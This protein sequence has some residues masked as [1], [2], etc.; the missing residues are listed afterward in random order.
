MKCEFIWINKANKKRI[1]WLAF[2]HNSS[3]LFARPNFDF[4]LQVVIIFIFQLISFTIDVSYLDNSWKENI[5]RNLMTFIEYIFTT[6]SLHKNKIHYLVTPK[7]K[8]SFLNRVKWKLICNSYAHGNDS[9]SFFL[10]VIQL[11]KRCEIRLMHEIPT[12]S[13]PRIVLPKLQSSPRQNRNILF[14]Y[15][16]TTRNWILAINRQTLQGILNI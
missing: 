1:S 5:F 13:E 9:V 16:C 3:L 2:C 11:H 8:N 4:L 15:R 6:P 12:P 14:H 10:F 7:I